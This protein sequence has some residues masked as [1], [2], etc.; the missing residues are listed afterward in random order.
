MIIYDYRRLTDPDEAALNALGAQ[1][2][3]VVAS[4]IDP[5]ATF[6][7]VVIME[8]A[9][10]KVEQPSLEDLM[11]IPGMVIP[12]VIPPTPVEKP[13][14]A[15]EMFAQYQREHPNESADIATNGG[16]Q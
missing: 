1:G 15:D 6:T 13:S 10:E 7:Q 2:Y 9:S 14:L 5:K 3:R 16:A 8:L 4:Y 11:K 12:T